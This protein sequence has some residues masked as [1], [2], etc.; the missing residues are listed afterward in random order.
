MI[1]PLRKQWF[2]LACL[3]IAHTVADT[4]VGIIA[5]VIVPLCDHYQVSLAMLIFASSLLAFSSNVFQIPVGHLQARLTSPIL[6]AGGVLLA[7]TSVFMTQLPFTGTLSV[8]A[9]SLIALVAGLGVA[10]VHPEG[11][12][13]VHGLNLIP[14]SLS[15]AVFMVA[16]FL[17]FSGGAIL[18]TTLVET[19]GM[20]S[21]AYLYLLAPL[22]II[23]LCLSG[24]RLPV[25]AEIAREP[26][27]D[28]DNTPR[29]PFIPLFIMTSILATS[30]QILA[31]LLPAYLRKEAGYSLSFSGLSFSLY[32]LGGMI[33]AV[34]WG[35]LAPRLGH[36]RILIGVTLAGAPMM[37][38]YLLWAPHSQW[39]AAF[40]TVTGLIVY[41]SFPLCI[42]LARYAHSSL[43]FG[44]RMGLASGG[45]WGI[46]AMVLWCIGPISNHTGLGPLLHLIWIG[47]II[48]ALIGLYA[49][50]QV[51]SSGQ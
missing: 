18:S 13:A 5:P 11:L 35:A 32:G 48:A 22:S 33:G 14:S 27:V 26:E 44:Q 28:R 37:L 40:L 51:K 20:Q 31:S 39:A 25:E 10:T 49:A 8:V 36:L 16:G 41:T 21:L 1:S 45:T 42:T 34:T 3:T 6:I 4:Y 19:F 50:R 30:A 46:A 17:G 2:Q 12:R 15:T 29:L 23:P 9:M 7:G 24:I 43:R 38:V 47:Y